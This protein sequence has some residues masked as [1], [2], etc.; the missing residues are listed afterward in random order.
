MG[1]VPGAGAEGVLTMEMLAKKALEDRFAE[2]EEGDFDPTQFRLSNTGRC[3]RYRMLKVLGYEPNDQEDMLAYFERGNVM[4]EVMAEY[5]RNQY[6]RR[7]RREFE[8]NTPYGDTG[9]IDYWIP[10]AGDEPT[11]IEIKSVSEGAKHFNL[12]KEDHVKQVQAYMHFLTDSRGN[13]RCERAEIVYLFFGRKFDDEV[14]EVRYDP[15]MGEQI[16]DE[17]VQLHKW[18]EEGFAPDPPEDYGPD[19]F[20]CFWCTE[21]AGDLEEHYCPFYAHCW[22][23][24]EPS[25]EHDE[26]LIFDEDEAMKELADK[27]KQIN[28]DYK[29]ANK[30]RKQL[31]K[32]KKK[33]KKALEKK[34]EEHG[35]DKAIIG[36]QRI[37]IKKQSGKTYWKPEKALEE[38]LIDEDTLE[39][40]RDV[41][42]ESDGYSRIYTKKIERGDI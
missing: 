16:E 29:K 42:Y 7:G 12:P 11:I 32:K 40:I 10:K 27:F 8:V 21:D 17:L 39:K 22:A 33:L 28:E 1:S 36:N 24:Y 34:F 18:K 37:M 31:K 30:K 20:P 19:S 3:Q 25:E 5:I 41:S 26:G 35:I 4:E 13:R 6:P 15:E 9:H 38:G 2:L 14:F 23:Y